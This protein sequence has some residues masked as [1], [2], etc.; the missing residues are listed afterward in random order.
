MKIDPSLLRDQGPSAPIN[1]Y[2]KKAGEQVVVEEPSHG[3]L[4]VELPKVNRQDTIYFYCLWYAVYH[5]SLS[6][7]L[8]Q[9]CFFY[10]K[11]AQL[12]AKNW[13]LEL[14]RMPGLKAYISPHD[15]GVMLSVLKGWVNQNILWGSH[16]Y[17]IDGC[18]MQGDGLQPKQSRSAGGWSSALPCGRNSADVVG[19]TN[20]RSENRGAHLSLILDC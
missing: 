6:P 5:E 16:E 18:A 14:E 1:P 19:R 13:E 2:G 15:L 17:H 9:S 11:R 3:K 7:S 12:E 20:R 4:V 10:A 8:T